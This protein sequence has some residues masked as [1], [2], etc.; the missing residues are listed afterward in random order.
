MAETQ[1]VA[2]AAVPEEAIPE[3]EGG[4]ALETVIAVAICALALIGPLIYIQY[5]YDVFTSEHGMAREGAAGAGLAMA[6]VFRTVSRTVLRT[7]VR[8]SAR[9]G[10][11]ASMKGAMQSG[12]RVATRGLFAS[13]FKSVADRRGSPKPKP[14]DPAGIRRANFKSLAFASVLLYASWVI[15]IG[16]GQPFEKLMTAEQAEAAQLLEKTEAK[17]LADRPRPQHQAWDLDVAVKAKQSELRET[18]KAYKGARDPAEQGR[19]QAI[20]IIENTEL[21]DLQI[22]FQDALTKAGGKKSQKQPPPV[23]GEPTVFDDA[24]AWLFTRA[25]YPGHVPWSSPIIWGG[26]VVFTLPLWFIFFCQSGMARARKLVLRHE[27]GID[28]GA[29]Q[30]YFAGAFSFMPLTSD[31]VVEGDDRERGIVALVG[32]LAPTLLAMALWFAAKTTGSLPLLLASD[33]FLIYPM[34]QTF[35]LDPLDGMRVWR[36]SKLVWTGVF[37]LVMSVFMFAGSEGLKSVI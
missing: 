11:R 29:I 16:L 30:L 3:P 1:P 13:M 2:S 12:M 15:V 37:I 32:L 26:A 22:Q 23:Q 17:K 31:V 24:V 18:R 20:L 35:P 19:L 8:T 5:R 10:M 4:G 33:A 9:A 25:P 27:T 7:I 36:W 14:T 6:V 21:D 34:V 28:G